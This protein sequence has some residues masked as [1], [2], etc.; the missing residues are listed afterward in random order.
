MNGVKE[1]LK[2]T[3]KIMQKDKS[4]WV[5]M[6]YNVK[7]HRIYTEPGEGRYKLTT[8]IN[9]NVTEKDVLYDG[10]YFMSM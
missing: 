10:Q 5:D 9:P 7:E 3:K 4:T 2:K 6:Y 8:Y 1:L